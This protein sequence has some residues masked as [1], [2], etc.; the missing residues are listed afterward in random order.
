M[1][2][3]LVCKRRFYETYARRHAEQCK[4]SMEKSMKTT[5]L[6]SHRLFTGLLLWLL[7]AAHAHATSPCDQ[8]SGYEVGAVL[9]DSPWYSSA[10]AALL[11][12][13]NHCMNDPNGCG[14][15]GNCPPLGPTTTC[16]SWSYV[17][18]GTFPS[19]FE[20]INYVT[21]YPDGSTHRLSFAVGTNVRGNPNGC[22]VYVS[23]IAPPL[24]NCGPLGNCVGDP[25]SPSSGVMYLAETDI[26]SPA[27]Q[28]AFKRFFN[29][30]DTTD[31]AGLSQGWRHS[32]SRSIA[33]RY[34]GTGY[35]GG[36]TTS[37]YNSSLHNDEATACT[38]G[39]TQ[40]QGQV[41]A[42]ASA[43][44]SYA[45]GVCTLS[46]GGAQIGTVALL[47]SS[48]PTPNPSTQVL[49]GY[50]A[51]RDDGQVVSFQLNGT[52]IVAPPGISLRLIERRHQRVCLRERK[53][54][55]TNGSLWA[56][57]LRL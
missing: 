54:N 38:S 28:L 15:G 9:Y 27:G 31:S 50:D 36:N 2:N 53:S 44:S 41:S 34:G 29:S 11:D 6:T 7:V 12:V 21:H 19:F 49:V 23:A 56:G 35:A 52:A 39:F 20:T 33:P 1:L 40:I 5:S 47:Y 57:R 8:W 30:N 51:T 22:Q 32:S 43:S 4:G 24:A 55:F 26:E 46:S 45:N 3:T 14:S 16:D 42:W 18:S 48:Q 10:N 25:I 17:V 13:F 37:T